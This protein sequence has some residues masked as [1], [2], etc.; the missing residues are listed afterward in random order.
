MYYFIK[1]LKQYAD[2][3]GRAR[4]REFWFYHLFYLLLMLALMAVHMMLGMSPESADMIPIILGFALIL[5]TLAVTVRRLHDINFSGW[6][7]LLSVVPMLNLV[8]YVFACI[9][10]TRGS[11][12]F[13]PD[14]KAGDHLIE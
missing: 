5:P 11:N 4:R 14:P 1:C 8:L 9:N 13:G 10:G 6:W 12:R 7:A 3:R 2:F